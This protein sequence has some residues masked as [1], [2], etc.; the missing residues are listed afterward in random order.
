MGLYC[1]NITFHSV[2]LRHSP[3][4]IPEGNPSA[5]ICSPTPLV[6]HRERKS[7]RERSIAI[8]FRRRFN[9]PLC[10]RRALVEQMPFIAFHFLPLLCL[11]QAFPPSGD[12]L[13][14]SPNLV[15]KITIVVLSTTAS[16]NKKQP[17][18]REVGNMSEVRHGEPRE[19]YDTTAQHEH[20][21]RP[22]A[23]LRRK[24]ILPVSSSD[25]KDDDDEVSDHYIRERNKLCGHKT[26]CITLPDTKTKTV[27]VVGNAICRAIVLK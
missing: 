18:L 4:N 3:S 16:A 13:H 21:R 26:T 6:N 19:K 8:T 2:C 10:C 14:A 12:A 1:C 5:V 24:K 22:H 17:G 27:R 11:L 15:S 25:G 23:F 20:T 9:Y 7:V